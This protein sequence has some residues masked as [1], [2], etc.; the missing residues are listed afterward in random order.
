MR[1]FATPTTVEIPTIGNL[2]DDV[3]RNGAEAPEAVVFNRPAAAGGWEEVTAAGFLEEVRGV[4]KGLVAAG[5]DPGDRVALIS[6]TRYEWTLLDYAIWFAGAVG[7]PIYE[8]SS[9]D[10]VAWILS[11]SGARVV[12]C[13]DA[14]H[15]ARV[16]AT[17]ATLPALEHLW[18]IEDGAIATLT[19]LGTGVS[20]AELETRRQAAGPGDLATLIYTSGTTGR[21][22][23]CMLTH[24]NFQTELG[25]IGRAHV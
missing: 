5:V 17:R 6:K 9:A 11:D 19:E 16:E 25:E 14:G 18:T 1:E 3:V 4:A 7:V 15:G 24:D 21:P 8:T 12:V 13:E 10:Q 22:K 23:G 2:T 20:D